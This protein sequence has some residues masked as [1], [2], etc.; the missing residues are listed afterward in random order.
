MKIV[1]DIQDEDVL[2]DISK[3][4]TALVFLCIFMI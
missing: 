2:F 1:I 3:R 4:Q